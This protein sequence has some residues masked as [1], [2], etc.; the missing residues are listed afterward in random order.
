[1]LQ[2]IGDGWLGEDDRDAVLAY[3]QAVFILQKAVDI[4]AQ[5]KEL[6]TQEEKPEEKEERRWKENLILP[7][8]GVALMFAPIVGMEAAAALGLNNIAR[9]IAV[10]GELGNAAFAT[11]ET[12]RDPASAMVNILGIFFSVGNIAKAERDVK[13][14]R[15]VA[16]YHMRMVSSEI[17][18]LGRFFAD[19]DSKVQTLQRKGE[20]RS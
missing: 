14:I 5:T 16:Q 17:L 18:C 8:I 1:M 2:I 20:L 19:R 7:S 10:V 13:A 9:L 15:G 6:G 4:M 3:A 11:Y 12:V